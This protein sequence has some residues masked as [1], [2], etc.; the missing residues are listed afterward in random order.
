MSHTFLTVA[1]PFDA[2]RSSDLESCLDQMGNP[3]CPDVRTQLRNQGIHFVSMSVVPGDL[4]QSSYWVIEASSDDPDPIKVLSEQLQVPLGNAAEI[5]GLVNSSQKTSDEIA[6]LM[7]KH[8]HT[9][10]QSLFS[11]PGLC[12]SGTPGMSLGRIR[13]EYELDREVR[14]VLESGKYQGT[15]LQILEHVRAHFKDTKY[16]HLLRQHDSPLLEPAPATSLSVSTI[17]SGLFHFTWP[18]WLVSLIVSLILTGIVGR[19]EGFFWAFLA[20]MFIAGLCVALFLGLVAWGYSILRR[21]ESTDLPD[22]TAPDPDRYR[23]V[24]TRENRTEQNHLFGISVMKTGFVRNFALRIVF[25]VI[26]RAATTISRPGFLGELGTIHFARWFLL[27]GTNKLLFFSNYGGSWE[28]YLE[29]FITK[30]HAGLT[31]VWS[32]TVGF[33]RTKNV[34]QDGATD[35]DRFKRWARRQQHPTRFWYSAYPYLTTE[36]IRLNTAIR[37]G[38]ASAV[39]EDE[40][41]EWLSCFGSRPRS[42]AILENFD[43]QAIL[44]GNLKYLNHAECLLLRLPE[45]VKDA[46]NWLQSIEPQ[47]S[48]GDEPPAGVAKL[49]AFTQTGLSRLGLDD[50]SIAEFP[51][52]FQEGISTPGRSRV[53]LDTGDDKPERWLWG[54]GESTVDVALLVYTD[55]EQQLKDETEKILGDFKTIGGSVIQQIP[56]SS[57]DP[58]KPIKE[59]FGF[60]DG[61]SQPIIRGTNRWI[62]DSDPNHV[63][64]PGEF[65]LGYLDN[66]GFLPLSPTV[67]ATSDPHKVLPKLRDS[68]PEELPNF[69][70]IGANM[71]RDLGRNGTFLVIRQLEQDVDAFNKFLEEAATRFDGKPGVPP[72]FSPYQTAEWLAA[73]VIGR[74]RDGTSLVRYPHGPGTG[75]G[76]GPKKEV[77]PDNE[78]LL[79]AEDPLGER[80]P[81]GSHIRRTNPRDSLFPNSPDQ[82]SIT[83]RHRILRMGRAYEPQPEKYGNSKPGLLFMCLNADIERQFEFIQQTWAGARLFHGL[84]GEADPILGRGGK[85]GRLTIPTERGPILVSGILDFVTVRGGGYFFM[86]GQRTLRFLANKDQPDGY[87]WHYE[88]VPTEPESGFEAVAQPKRSVRPTW[89]DIH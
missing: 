9:V 61:V 28:S 36:R 76:D 41:L 71:P 17:V 44:F 35:G 84:D 14:D 10:G 56:L 3:A 24:V 38:L 89:D 52:A 72:G 18:Y 55:S 1:I 74:W 65:I 87:K 21:L 70:R 85:G 25:W 68:Q 20:F 30:A 77:K 19:Q 69:T 23:E 81:Y 13:D 66:R 58:K 45:S 63:V 22:N 43:I 12:F 26:V 15:A 86:P 75:W 82:I 49:I 79:G 39:T 59:P 8:S 54:H 50:Q 34:F 5:C 6:R 42:G 33:P 48:F 46:Q 16:G 88:S 11:T 32:N 67:P 47:I 78:F 83:N 29:D 2:G 53:L 73:K 51:I 37:Q 27:P 57:Y 62:S 64:E 7:R 60:V 40:A 80:C 4:G 31:G